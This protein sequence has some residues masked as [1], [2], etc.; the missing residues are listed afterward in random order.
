MSTDNPLPREHPSTYTVQDLSSGEELKRLHIH[1]QVLTTCMGGVLSEQPDPARFRCVLDI[2]CGPGGW[3]IEM[4]RTYPHLSRL[5]GV[6]IS[7]TILDYARAQARAMQVDDRVEFH[8]MDGLRMLEFPAASFDLVNERSGMSWLRT[9]D[10]PKFLQE[11]QRVTRPGGVIRVTEFTL[12]SESTSPALKRL[13]ALAIEAFYQSGHLFTP[14]PDG[15][16]KELARLLRQQGLQDLQT[17]AHVMQQR[18][19]TPQG[20]HFVEDW[21]HLFRVIVPFLRKWT[22][23]PEDYQDIY[24]QML[25]EMQQPDFVATMR[26]LT[27]W[28][29]RSLRL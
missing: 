7:N 27:A 14:A 25:Y 10:W 29:T 6:D 15:V 16:T 12:V 1:D 21:Q 2:G 24:Q 26:L 11:C 8:Q 20:Q 9:W 19:S 22:Q 18:G 4:A 3:L 13:V 28:G 23:L 17:R 5:V